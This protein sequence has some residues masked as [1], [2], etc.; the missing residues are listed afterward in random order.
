M[1]LTIILTALLAVG[2]SLIVIA[3][4]AWS[5]VTQRRD[6]S[7]TTPDGGGARPA[8]RRPE[9]RAPRPRYAPVDG[10]V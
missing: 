6:W 8:G 7:G 4:L 9:R 10:R 3:P 5:I 2:V 1:I